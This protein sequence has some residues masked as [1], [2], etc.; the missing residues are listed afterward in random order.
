[1]WK[2]LWRCYA[3]CFMVFECP[4]RV[5]SHITLLDTSA[6]V[7][8]W[9]RE[10]GPSEV[11]YGQQPTTTLR[12]LWTTQ[13]SKHADVVKEAIWNQRSVRTPKS[14]PSQ[15]TLDFR[16][17]ASSQ[18]LALEHIDC[19]FVV[20]GK[21]ESAARRL[22]SDYQTTE[23]KLRNRQTVAQGTRSR[24]PIP[25]QTTTNVTYPERRRPANGTR[26]KVYS[27]V[28]KEGTNSVIEPCDPS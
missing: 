27:R 17:V 3:Y 28:T 16:R 21:T 15:T 10:R 26:T 6:A 24:D 19:T 25:A 12:P 5:F 18:Q 13:L 2:L 7:W 4:T 23:R 20:L 9:L 11:W 1:M 8:C 22:S 14:F